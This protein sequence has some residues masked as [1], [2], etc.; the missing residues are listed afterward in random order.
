MAVETVESN[1]II[2]LKTLLEGMQ[3]AHGLSPTDVE[4]DG[5]IGEVGHYGLVRE[6]MGRGKA[7]AP[8]QRHLGWAA[9]WGR[10]QGRVSNFS[11][12][13]QQPPY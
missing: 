3:R 8:Q 12:P 4:Q 13:W 2:D 5:E 9:E 11:R 1:P 6:R 7:R 10:R